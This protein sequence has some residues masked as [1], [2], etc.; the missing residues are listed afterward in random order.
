MPFENENQIKNNYGYTNSNI[1]VD[2]NEENETSKLYENLDRH[3]IKQEINLTPTF[4][5]FLQ[6]E[7]NNYL[8]QVNT[9]KSNEILNSNDSNNQLHNDLNQQNIPL[10]QQKQQLNTKIQMP[11]LSH[12]AEN[13]SMKHSTNR[14]I[15]TSSNLD[16]SPQYLN[17]ILNN[18]SSVD[19]ALSI[20]L[21]QFSNE[22][23]FN[24]NTNNKLLNS[25]NNS[26][27][28]QFVDSNTE[29]YNKNQNNQINKDIKNSNSVSD[30]LNYTEPT[31]NYTPT[32]FLE[33]LNSTF[34]SNDILNSKSNKIQPVSSSKHNIKENNE[35][36]NNNNSI[37]YYNSLKSYNQKYSSNTKDFNVNMN[38][39][40]NETID[41][42]N[43]NNN[44]GPEIKI[45]DT[46]LFN[47]ILTQPNDSMIPLPFEK[48]EEQN[49]VNENSQFP[50]NLAPSLSVNSI[51]ISS[52]N[53]TDD[54]YL[55]PLLT[56]PSVDDQHSNSIHEQMRLGR[57]QLHSNLKSKSRSSSISSRSRSRSNS[58]S[59]LLLDTKFIHNRSSS[60]SS[61]LSFHSDMS[62]SE[63][64]NSPALSPG[65]VPL[66]VNNNDNYPHS[67]IGDDESFDNGVNDDNNSN[68]ERKY[69]CEICG[70]NFTRPYNLKS[71]LRTHTNE[72][73]Y[74]CRQCGKK[75]AR[76]HD[77]KRHEDLHSGEKKFQCKGTFLTKFNEDGK[78]KEWGC[79]KRFARTDALRRH[80]W[81]ENGK[82]CIKPYAIECIGEGTGEEWDNE[83]VKVAMSNAIALMKSNEA[84]TLK[85]DEAPPKLKA[86]RGRPRKI[87][88]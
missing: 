26:S 64:N 35:E 46:D 39:D 7:P 59:N 12:I 42:N 22:L 77:R 57:Q 54:G 23:D 47:L 37:L 88:S 1:N 76:Q 49:G 52:P 56:V 32:Q 62:G 27:D 78:P 9:S 50:F 74:A 67:D 2:K 31:L 63:W 43:N 11:L 20:K 3:E 4:E 15:N 87:N 86:K 24:Y 28:F 83:A 84:D 13:H 80:F 44:F 72:R 68:D 45:E 25:F 34:D 79:N 5:N 38:T 18:P 58:R 36:L 85:N 10:P 69:I 33:L 75:F 6:F 40:L 21:H 51:A 65:G 55:V 8:G 71:H 66:S 30:N 61:R 53:S 14:I 73:P 60:N 17:P 41:A 82:S 81:T 70:K 48:N 29:N 19:S 16:A